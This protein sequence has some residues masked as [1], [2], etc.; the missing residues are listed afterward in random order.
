MCGSCNRFMITKPFQHDDYVFVIVNQFCID[1][2]HRFCRFCVGVILLFLTFFTFSQLK[3]WWIKC[4]YTAMCVCTAGPIVRH[5]GQWIATLRHGIISSCQ[6]AAT[7]EIVKALLVVYS[8]RKQ[9]Y[10]KYLDFTFFTLN[11]GSVRRTFLM[12]MADF[13]RHFGFSAILDLPTCLK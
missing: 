9:R 7:S 13:G 3:I 10:D 11:K 8:C 12:K 6:S 4:K 1:F 2:V 5:R